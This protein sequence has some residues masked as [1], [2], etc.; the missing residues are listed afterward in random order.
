VPKDS[1]DGNKRH[2]FGFAAK[3]FLWPKLLYKC[4]SSGKMALRYK[5]CTTVFDVRKFET[6]YDKEKLHEVFTEM[7]HMISFHSVW[8]FVQAVR[9]STHL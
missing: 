8:H 7:H 9:C 3:S 6:V 2:I 1:K 4:D 5:N